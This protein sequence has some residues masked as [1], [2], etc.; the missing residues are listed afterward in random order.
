MNLAGERLLSRANLALNQHRD[1]AAGD[2]PH[3]TEDLPHGRAAGDDLLLGPHPRATGSRFLVD[4]GDAGN[5]HDTFS[6]V[7]R[8]RLGTERP[9][10]AFVPGKSRPYA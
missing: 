9:G 2:F 3:K 6:S 4:A 1:I 8:M 5:L 10:T 7:R